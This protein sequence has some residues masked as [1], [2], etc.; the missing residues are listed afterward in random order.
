MSSSACPRSDDLGEELPVRDGDSLFELVLRPREG[1]IIQCSSDLDP[2]PVVQG[3]R[4]YLRRV[5]R[6]IEASFTE[7]EIQAP[8]NSGWPVNK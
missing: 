4:V 3:D 1:G 5:V 6:D 8:N 7:E 2:K